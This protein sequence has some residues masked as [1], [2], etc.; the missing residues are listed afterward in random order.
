[1]LDFV[2]EDEVMRWIGGEAGG[3]EEAIESIDRWIARWEANGVGQFAVEC[4]GRVIGR[5][6]LLVWD[7]RS[8]ETST[9]ERAGGD[10]VIELGLALARADWGPGV[11]PE[12]VRAV[13]TLADSGRG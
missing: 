10:A 7:G 5:V 11:A 9:Y 12:R 8:W 2:G 6:G 13:L 4:E 1:M 3:R